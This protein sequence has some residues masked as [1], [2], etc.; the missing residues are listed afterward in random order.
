LFFGI[1]CVIIGEEFC[2]A[3]SM[4]RSSRS[5]KGRCDERQSLESGK[6]KHSNSTVGNVRE[7]H[8]KEKF[9]RPRRTKKTS[10]PSQ[11][12]N[13]SCQASKDTEHEMQTG[14]NSH[15]QEDTDLAPKKSRPRMTKDGSTV[16]GASAKARSRSEGHGRRTSKLASKHEC[17]EEDGHEVETKSKEDT[18]KSILT[19]Q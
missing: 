12:P 5:V 3:D 10:K 2:F 11:Q 13:D 1:A 9:D 16:G 18:T 19:E 4:E 15:Q 14:D 17:L 6:C 8:A 7:S